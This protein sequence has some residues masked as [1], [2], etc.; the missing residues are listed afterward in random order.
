VGLIV[1]RV[2]ELEAGAEVIVVETAGGLFTPL[3]DARTNVDLVRALMPASVLLV[4][5]D[6]LGVLHDVGACVAAASAR[7]IAI[8]AIALSAAATSDASAGTNAAELARIGYPG[9][10]AFPR[11]AWAGAESQRAAARVWEALERLTPTP[12]A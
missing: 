11:A 2:E 3:D 12:L 5:P 10:S 9:A 6:R 1:R 8:D 4:A 7:G